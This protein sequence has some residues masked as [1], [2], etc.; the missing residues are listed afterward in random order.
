MKHIKTNKQNIIQ[1]S[2]H[3]LPYKK[4]NISQRKST[5]NNTEN[6]QLLF[7]D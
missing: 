7:C 2:T 5:Q 1:N 3:I 4:T 6:T